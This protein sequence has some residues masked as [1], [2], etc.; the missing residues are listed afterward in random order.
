MRNAILL[1]DRMWSFDF[2]TVLQVF[3]GDISPIQKTDNTLDI[4]A[5]TPRVRLD[6]RIIVGASPLPAPNG[7]DLVVVP[8]IA[9]PNPL[10]DETSDSY[11][12]LWDGQT[13]CEMARTWLRRAHACGAEIASLGTGSFFLGWCGL[14]D[15]T[16]V[17]THWMFGDALQHRFPKALIETDVLFSHDETKRIWT[18]GGGSSSL[19]LCLTLMRRQY[20]QAVNAAASRTLL[21]SSARGE[22]SPQYIPEKSKASEHRGADLS[23]ITIPVLSHPEFPWSV[24][25]MA[26]LGNMSTR[27]MQRRFKQEY[28]KSAIQWLL[29][30]RLTLACELLETTTLTTG[31]I[32]KRVGMSSSDLLRKNFQSHLGTSPAEYRKAHIAR[33]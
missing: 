31:I 33:S 7:Y 28:G 19:D 15:D 4:I 3:D 1:T 25:S 22:S 29:E 11:R 23:A 27:T 18:C 5:A 8:G 30:E 6:H 13:S 12:N 20:G 14:L 32:A 17:T 21:V 10:L 2:S 16:R 24:E 9:Y 26:Q